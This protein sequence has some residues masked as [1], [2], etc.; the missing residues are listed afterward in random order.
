MTLKMFFAHQRGFPLHQSTL[1]IS[2]STM[3]NDN[4][5]RQID[6]KEF[7]TAELFQKKFSSFFGNNIWKSDEIKNFVTTNKNLILV[8]FEKE[9]I[10]GLAIF[11][12]VGEGL[13]IY[14]I[15]VEP[16]FRNKSI[17]TKFLKEAKNFVY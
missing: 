11:I 7:K 13:D 17:G 10:I 1:F 6:T 12:R 14:T 15:F 8:A 2:L 9:K 5:I 16:L 3:Q 4:N